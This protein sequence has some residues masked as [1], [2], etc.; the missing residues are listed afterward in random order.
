MKVTPIAEP[1]PG[2]HISAT[3]PILRPETEA[4]WRQRLNF[5]AGRALTA[6]ALELE[7]ENRAARLAT[8]ARVGTPGIVAGLEVAL[9]APP[10]GGPL[11]PN[12]HFLHVL[13]GH[14]ISATGEDVVVPRALRIPLDDI[15]VQL[16]R[17]TTMEQLP[18]GEKDEI[19]LDL[20]G[21]RLRR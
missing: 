3:A 13:P 1:L 7:Q 14:G 4:G 12:K 21:S 10:G 18:A 9:E 2:E 15:A 16:A 6:E 8:W 5:W 17:F 20:G 11:T 19:L